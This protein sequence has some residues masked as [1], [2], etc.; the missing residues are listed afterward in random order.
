[1][2]GSLP[3]SLRGVA[4]D[5]R[6]HQACE[7]EHSKVW[8]TPRIEEGAQESWGTLIN[9]KGIYFKETIQGK[10]KGNQGKEVHQ[11][12]GRLSL[13]L[14][15]TS[16]RDSITSLRRSLDCIRF[17]VYLLVVAF[18]LRSPYICI[19][20][21]Y[22]FSPLGF[23]HGHVDQKHLC[24]FVMVCLVL[25]AVLVVKDPRGYSMF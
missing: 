18:A 11:G 5:I 20:L 10:G 16:L 6:A 1:M 9:C 23:F 13:R 2:H 21:S 8:G 4:L 25:L 24:T 17:L 3:T 19:Y 14:A 7:R 22:W 15:G 12:K